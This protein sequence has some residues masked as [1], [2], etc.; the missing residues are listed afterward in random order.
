[1][2]VLLILVPV[3]LWQYCW[4]FVYCLVYYNIDPTQVPHIKRKTFLRIVKLM[5]SI[6]NWGY[7]VPLIMKIKYTRNVLKS[8]CTLMFMVLYNFKTI[9]FI[10]LFLFPFMRRENSTITHQTVYN[11]SYD[12]HH[13]VVST[14]QRTVRPWLRVLSI[15]R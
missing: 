15:H 3:Q 9:L 12:Q 8:V 4:T 13:V 1:M 5:D 2:T 10:L 7:I 11:R 6:D 14:R